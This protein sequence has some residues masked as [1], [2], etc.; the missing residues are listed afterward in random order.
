M[1]NSMQNGENCA[2]VKEIPSQSSPSGVKMW[3]NFTRP[4]IWIYVD[5]TRF[6]N[7]Q[8]IMVVIGCLEK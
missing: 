5:V 4:G 7:N 1:P 3:S 2:K 8:W 6:K